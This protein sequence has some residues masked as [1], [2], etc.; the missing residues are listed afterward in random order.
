MT[1]KVGTPRT[2][3]EGSLTDIYFP[4]LPLRTASKRRTI[5]PRAPRQD[6]PAIPLRRTRSRAKRLGQL[7]D[8]ENDDV[9]KNLDKA[10]SKHTIREEQGGSPTKINSHFRTS[11]LVEGRLRE[12]E[13]R[14]R[15]WLTDCQCRR[16]SGSGSRIQDPAEEPI[17]RC[18]AKFAS[19][20]PASCP[21]GSQGR[22]SAHSSTRRS[23]PDSTPE[24]DSDRCTIGVL[25]SPSIVCSR[26][27]LGATRGTRHGTRKGF[28]LH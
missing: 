26:C 20:S 13:D 22:Y 28:H 23:S 24:C 6:A 3:L 4:A 25:T 9:K 12:S 5:A 18:I 2:F 10:P 27:Q 17:P 21:S 11:K 1:R 7:P 15:T 19:Y 8:Q 16:D 14:I